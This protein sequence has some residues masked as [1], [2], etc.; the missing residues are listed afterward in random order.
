MAL[1]KSVWIAWKET[2]GGQTAIRAVRSL[3]AGLTW[4]GPRDVAR[5]DGSSDHPFLIGRGADAFL[6]WFAAQEGYRL[7]RIN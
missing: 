1:G 4:S 2:Q 5:T 3:D 7:V 6:S